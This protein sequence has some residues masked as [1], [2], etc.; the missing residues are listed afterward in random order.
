M[1]RG[2]LVESVAKKTGMSKRQTEEVVAT[3]IDQIQ[4]GVKKDGEV[5]LVGFGTFKKA[6]RKARKGRNPQTGETIR[7]KRK[8]FPKFIPS[9]TWEPT[10]YKSR[11]ARKKTARKKRS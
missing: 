3:V 8:T 7:I 4:T 6:V 2:Q 1:N 11:V 10:K 5:R 9:K